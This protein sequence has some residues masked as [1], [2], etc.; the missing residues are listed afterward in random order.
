MPFRTEQ[1]KGGQDGYKP[2]C[3]RREQHA[4]LNWEALYDR[5]HALFSEKLL[6]MLSPLSAHRKREGHQ[7]CLEAVFSLATGHTGAVNYSGREDEATLQ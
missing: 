5:Q 7:A 1:E 6:L 2:V 4:S 3:L